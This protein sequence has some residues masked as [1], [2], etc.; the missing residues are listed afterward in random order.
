MSCNYLHNLPSSCDEKE[1]IR[2]ADENQIRI[3]NGNE[4]NAVIPRVLFVSCLN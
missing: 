2:F 3:T 4:S 1:I